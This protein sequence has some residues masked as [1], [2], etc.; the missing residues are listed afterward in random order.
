[1]RITVL[2]ENTAPEHSGL[3]AEHGLSFLI[4]TGGHLLLLDAGE[5]GAFWDNAVALGED[6]G[7]VEL[8]AISHGHHDHA[9]GFV[10]FFQGNA[11]APVYL[12]A[13]AW[14]NFVAPRGGEL[15]Y[16]GMAAAL[17]KYAGRFRTAEGICSLLS[18]VW[19]TPPPE[20]GRG[21]DTSLWERDGAGAL[22]PDRFAHEQAMVLDEGKGLV[23]LSPC[24]HCGIDRI[25]AAVCAA[26]PGR[27]LLGVLGGFHMRAGAVGGLNR[28]EEEVRRVARQLARLGAGRIWTGHCT[29]NAARAILQEELGERLQ[30]PLTTGLSIEL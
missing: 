23:I 8:A 24:S 6:L 19:L 30:P 28:P 22:G 16:I 21:A 27:P 14:G 7:T 18:G 15:R 20:E 29:G 5:T 9:N 11:S 12:R 13:S 25:A 2:I 26:F 1:M 17:R 4:R 3:Q 10:R